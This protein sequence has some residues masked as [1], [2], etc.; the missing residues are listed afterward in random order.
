MD[1]VQ[2]N[3]VANVVGATATTADTAAIRK[4]IGDNLDFSE[5]A[6]HFKA[7]PDHLYEIYYLTFVYEPAIGFPNRIDTM[8]EVTYVSSLVHVVREWI[9]FMAK[10]CDPKTFIN[11][12]RT[13]D[14]SVSARIC[15]QPEGFDRNLFAVMIR[16]SFVPPHLCFPTS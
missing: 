13:L 1:K 15:T 4:I 5:F 8:E 3:T 10:F 14:R 6:I 16:H 9:Q 12:S 7:I 2:L 11:R